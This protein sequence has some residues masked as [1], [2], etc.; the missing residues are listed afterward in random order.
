MNTV[1]TVVYGWPSA[2][3]G[4]ALLALGPVLRRAWLSAIGAVLSA[5]FCAYM[6]M[7][8]PPVR[9]LGAIAL[10]G[11]FSS[12][13]A[14]HQKKHAVAYLL[15]VPFFLQVARTAYLVTRT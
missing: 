1:T 14:V 13:A 4:L 8:P 10:I 5:G 11:N 12:V 7:S 6:L 2:L 15:L 9:W 3:S